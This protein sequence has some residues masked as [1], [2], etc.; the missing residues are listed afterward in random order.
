MAETLGFQA[1]CGA[2]P[3]RVCSESAAG[4][5]C[6]RAADSPFRKFAAETHP[7]PLCCS[8]RIMREGY[9]ANVANLASIE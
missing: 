7:S 4:V 5:R 3:P 1:I 2:T 8:I 9:H 6:N